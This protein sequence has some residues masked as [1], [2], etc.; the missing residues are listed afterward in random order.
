[1]ADLNE[2]F[3]EREQSTCEKGALE[4]LQSQSPFSADAEKKLIR[5]IDLMYVHAYYQITRG[6]C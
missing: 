6:S 5:K 3:A 4:E 1:M 2:K